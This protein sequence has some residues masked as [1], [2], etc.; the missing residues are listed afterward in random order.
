MDMYS[1]YT[2]DLPVWWQDDML[3]IYIVLVLCIKMHALSF[4]YKFLF[5]H[6]INESPWL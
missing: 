1:S 3:R 4:A 2:P 5:D 6:T